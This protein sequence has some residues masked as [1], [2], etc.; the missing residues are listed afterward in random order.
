MNRRQLLTAATAVSALAITG[1]DETLDEIEVEFLRTAS[2]DCERTYEAGTRECELIH[3]YAT[4]MVARGLLSVKIRDTAT[5]YPATDY[6]KRLL[7]Q[8]DSKS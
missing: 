8:Y 1:K 2:K 4:R 5:Y 3:K 6:G 7:T